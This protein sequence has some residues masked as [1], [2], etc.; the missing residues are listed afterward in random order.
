MPRSAPSDLPRKYL[1]R[2]FVTF[3]CARNLIALK[4]QNKKF[5]Y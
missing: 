3:C 1:C 4:K 2:S 5:A